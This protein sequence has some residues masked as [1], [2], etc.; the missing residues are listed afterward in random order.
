MPHYPGLK[1][2]VASKRIQI[3]RDRGMRGYK[4]NYMRLL[5]EMNRR[6]L[7][8]RALERV[9]KQD[10]TLCYTLLNYI[11]S[12]H[13]GLREKVTS[14]LSAMVLLGEEEIRRWAALSAPSDMAGGGRLW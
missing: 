7:D 11:N 6:E 3:L 1:S 10:A 8:F 5:R 12:K 2:L 14:L 4:L 13:F 9:I